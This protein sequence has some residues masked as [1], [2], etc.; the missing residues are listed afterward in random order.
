MYLFY[1]LYYYFMNIA[2]ISNALKLYLYYISYI[3]ILETI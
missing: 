1:L 3:T 2:I